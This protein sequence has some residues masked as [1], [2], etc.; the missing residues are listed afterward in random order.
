MSTQAHNAILER[1]LRKAEAKPIIDLASDLLKEMVNFSTHA[2]VRCI[3][4]RRFRQD[5]DIALVAL[6]RHIIEM[7]DG[8]EVLVSQSCAIPAIPLLRSSFESLLFQKYILEN[9]QEYSRRALAWLVGYVYQR[10]ASYER[11]DSTTNRGQHFY[12]FVESDIFASRIDLSSI[13]SQQAIN[14]LQQF[15]NKGH[16]QP[17]ATAFTSS[18]RTLSWYQL[19]GGPS[20][21]AALAQRVNMRATYDILYREWSRVTHGQD[22]LAF[23]DRTSEGESA[24]GR[25]R[26]TERLK[27]VSSFAASFLLGATRQTVGKFRPG[28]TLGYWY[29]DKIRERYIQLTST[30]IDSIVEAF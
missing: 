12:S 14:N 2:L 23:I 20:D 25:I 18:G 24:L 10:L 26:N 7:T 16:I 9:E 29:I 19:N 17:I 21:L 28:E 22:L 5:E 3:A 4:E 11:L 27:E 30:S 15:L 6:Y 1:D 8:I 13:G